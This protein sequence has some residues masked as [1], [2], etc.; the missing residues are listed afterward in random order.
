MDIKL[1]HGD[2]RALLKSLDDCSVDS[3][4]TDPPYEIGFMGRAWDSSG[5]AYDVG[6][7]SEVLRVMK[8]GAHLLSF[9]GTRTYH[10]MACA[11][12]DAG[13]EIR[14]QM[15]WLYGSGF[16]K[17]LDLSKAIDKAAGVERAVIGTAADFARDGAKRKSDGT[18]NRPHEHQ[19]GHGYGD[20]WSTPVTVPST[21]AGKHWQG[22]GT[23]LKPA[24]EPICLARKPLAARTVSGN[25]LEHGTGA[26]NIDACRIPSGEDHRAKCESV[27]GF[28]SNRNGSCYGEWTGERESSW[29]PAGRFPSN[30]LLD[31]EA[32][33]LIDRQLDGASRFFY[34][35][36]AS[37]AE[38]EAGL[39]NRERRKVN[40]G[41]QTPIDNPFQRGETERLN[42]HPTVKP[43]DLMRY[44]VR[45][46][47]PP[48]GVVLDPFM[49]SGTTLLAARE[50]GFSAIGMEV[51]FEH[52][53]IAR[54]KL[55]SIP[56]QP[57][58]F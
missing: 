13:F 56:H 20:R 40:D 33:A 14:D 53:E 29:S 36:K 1:L 5:I 19:G 3:V 46:V 23:A 21:E 17:S 45:L 41:R 16:P 32:A 25:V 38:R 49:G 12:E 34:T 35:A 8:P 9:G 57:R 6:M 26:L 52:F 28:D 51:V 55:S 27:V 48:R 2:C 37:K 43:L 18:H 39:R 30:L 10:R 44:L 42:T 47:T 7:W 22:W 54:E 11:I 31:E 50:E 24:N 58:L 15:Q 4:V